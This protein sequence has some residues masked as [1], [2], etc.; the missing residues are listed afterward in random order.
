LKIRDLPLPFLVVVL[1]AQKIAP[2]A[3][4]VQVIT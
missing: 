2:A 1:G 4:R 3:E